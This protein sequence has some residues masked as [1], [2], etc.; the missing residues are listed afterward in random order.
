MGTVYSSEN[1]RGDR[2][3]GWQQLIGEIYANLDIEISGAE[4]FFSQICRDDLGDIEFTSVL[5]DSEFARRTRRHISQD[6]R[7]AYLYVLVRNGDLNVVQFGR[8]TVVRTGQFTLLDLNSPYLF[9]HNRRVEKL[10]IKIP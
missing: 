5:A 1:L 9:R 6:Q 10:G 7:E 4:N 2:R 3:K 8:D